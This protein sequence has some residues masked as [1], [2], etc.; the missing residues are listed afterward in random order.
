MRSHARIAL[1]L[2]AILLAACAPKGPDPFLVYEAALQEAREAKLPSDWK[3]QTAI[4]FGTDL[5]EQSFARAADLM[6]AKLPSD[7]S[8]QWMA[9]RVELELGLTRTGTSLVVSDVCASCIGA[10]IELKGESSVTISNPTGTMHRKLP[11]TGALKALY[12][13]HARKDARGDVVILVAPAESEHW[14]L[15]IH[16]ESVGERFQ[17]LIMAPVRDKLR[18]LVSKG[19]LFSLP[20]ARV[21]HDGVLP[22][23]AIRVRS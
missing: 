5:V 17:P 13:L 11:W 6:L 18:E 9:T 10:R 19:T 3:A 8:V 12:R 16:F 14:E 4:F 23:K 22:L 2:P 20:L 7:T 21:E 15:D 1:L